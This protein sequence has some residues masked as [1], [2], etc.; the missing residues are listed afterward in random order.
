MSRKPFFRLAILATL[1]WA[2]SGLGQQPFGDRDLLQ[3]F[4]SR[5]QPAT[6]GRAYARTPV[7]P[8]VDVPRT[9]APAVHRSYFPA[10]GSGQSPNRNVPTR[11]CVPGRRSFLYH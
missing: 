8:R 4:T 11:H 1:A 10:R 9:P 2:S 3:P 7:A 5:R 6:A